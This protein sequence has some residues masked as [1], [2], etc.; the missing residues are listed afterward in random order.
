M[1][2]LD[3]QT[4]LG[5]NSGSVGSEYTSLLGCAPL[6]LVFVGSVAEGHGTPNS[7]LD[8]YAI[9]RSSDFTRIND[10]ALDTRSIFPQFNTQVSGVDVDVRVVSENF[11]ENAIQSVAEIDYANSKLRALRYVD[12]KY[13]FKQV[14][15]ILGRLY[16]GTS[17]QDSLWH[18][19][20]TRSCIDAELFKWFGAL[21]LGECEN[22]YDDFTG[23]MEVGDFESGEWQLNFLVSECIKLLCFKEHIYID[24]EKWVPYV[25]RGSRSTLVGELRG[26]LVNNASIQSKFDVCNRAIAE[27]YQW[28]Y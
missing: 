14:Q 24:R 16:C 27:G 12:K 10:L 20:F 26:M 18:K 9:V 7:D 19:S 21:S 1:D 11:L 17:S 13:H 15:E 4:F 22:K 25:S 5:E 3:L 23:F 2:Y 28:I 6:D 8:S